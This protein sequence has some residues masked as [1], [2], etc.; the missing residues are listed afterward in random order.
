MGMI[1]KIV[2]ALQSDYPS[3]SWVRFG[4]GQ[5]PSPPYGVIKGERQ[6]NG[7]GIRVI[8][9]RNQGEGNQLEDDIYYV[10]SIL[11]EKVLTSRNGCVNMLSN[12]IEYT[13]VNA[14]SDD[15]TIS[16]EA[17]FL[18]PTKTF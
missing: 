9:H 18:M 12:M 8:I 1:D 13:D 16:M 3:I 2:I 10:A 4:D 5:L 6:V 15:N 7:R 14:V 17:L 11:A